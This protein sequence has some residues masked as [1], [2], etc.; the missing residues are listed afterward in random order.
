MAEPNAAF[1]ARLRDL[2]AT[3]EASSVVGRAEG[4]VRGLGHQLE[5]ACVAL[6]CDEALVALEREAFAQLE[7]PVVATAA[8]CRETTLVLL[9]MGTPFA[10]LLAGGTAFALTLQPADAAIAQLRP[11][12]TTDPSAAAFAPIHMGRAVVGAVTLLRDCEFGD[13]ELRLV[14]HLGEVLSL[15]VEGFRTERV[16]LDLFVRALPDVLAPEFGTSLR[17]ALERA[18]AALRLDATYRRKLQLALASAHL[19]ERGPEATELA[20]GILEQFDGYLRRLERQP[21]GRL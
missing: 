12:L 8:G 13:R 2:L 1:V 15:T 11:V 18:L 19:A 7:V 3:I 5:F 20:I 16:L 10:H 6:P 21:E 4:R 14:Q 17:P 9:P